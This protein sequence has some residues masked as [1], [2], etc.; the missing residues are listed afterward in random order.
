MKIIKIIFAILAGLFALMHCI[1]C[2]TL[3]L[4]GAHPSQIL[5]SLS[6]LLL[7]AA[8]SIVLFKSAFKKKPSDSVSPEREGIPY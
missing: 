1:Y 6:A 4:R 8:I 2:P 7:G 3:I 5:A